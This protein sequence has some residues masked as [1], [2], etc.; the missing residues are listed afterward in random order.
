MTNEAVFEASEFLK[1]SEVFP[2]SYIVSVNGTDELYISGENAFWNR[3]KP[4]RSKFHKQVLAL[5]LASNW[6]I[7]ADSL[8]DENDLTAIGEI[9]FTHP[10]P[11]KYG[12]I[13]MDMDYPDLVFV[14]EEGN[15][16]K[17][18]F[19]VEEYIESLDE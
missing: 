5:L 17:S 2:N 7:V 14:A 12:F 18:L 9:L 8:N 15:D 11:D 1:F 16:I 6:L 19:V 10:D 13:S 3:D 4:K